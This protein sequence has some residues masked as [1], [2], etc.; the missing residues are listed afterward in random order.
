MLN[1]DY[2]YLAQRN[3]F[4]LPF[5]LNKKHRILDI[6][7]TY[8]ATV[9]MLKDAD[10]CE[11]ACGVEI[12]PPAAEQAREHFDSI[13]IGDIETIDLPITPH[14]IDLIL[15]LDVLEHLIDPWRTI[16]KL[17]NYLSPSGFLIAKIPNISYYYMIL[18]LIKNDW[19]YCDSGILDKTH[20]RFFVKKTAIS[21]LECSGLKVD[22]VIPLDKCG[23]PKNVRFTMFE[24]FF[25]YEYLLIAREKSKSK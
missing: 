15:C 3:D 17:H 24:V 8:G 14:S 11:W 2:P 7:C 18:K 21:L 4:I 10:K 16:S 1:T 13:I 22:K 19:S 23:N 6:G 5:I 25:A 12:Y 20:L 9:K